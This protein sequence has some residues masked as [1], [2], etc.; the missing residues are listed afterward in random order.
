MSSVLDIKYRKPTDFGGAVSMGLM[1][2]SVQL[3]A[4]NKKKTFSHNSGFRYRNN[5]YVLG[6]LD[7]RGDY[8]PTYLD[9]QTY[10]TWNPDEHGP[11]EFHFLGNVSRNRYNFIPQ[12]RETDVGTI[13][14]AL[15]LTVCFFTDKRIQGSTPISEPFLQIAFQMYRS[16]RL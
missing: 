1:G 11:W 10:L 15:R 7:E 3:E 8:N 9:F 12:T 14:E 4:I 5:S 16:S 2:L 13:N 6:T